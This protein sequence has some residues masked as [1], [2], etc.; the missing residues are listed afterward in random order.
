MKTIVT[1]FLSATIYLAGTVPARSQVG[2]VFR[3]DTIRIVANDVLIEVATSDLGK[4]TLVSADIPGKLK[5][6]LNGLNLL[7]INPPKADEQIC[8][9]YT[10]YFGDDEKDYYRLDLQTRKKSG[11]KILI[12]QDE[13]FEYNKGSYMLVMAGRNFLIRIYLNNMDDVVKITEPEFMNTIA[14]AGNEIPVSRK[15]INGW[16]VQ[17]PDGSFN[18]FFIDEQPPLTNDV[19]E[20]GAGIGAGWIKNEFVSDLHFRIGI[21]IGNKAIVSNIYFAEVEAYYNFTWDG[22]FV[23]NGFLSVGYERNFSRNPEKEKWFGLSLGYLIDRNN[24][25]FGKNTFKLSV[26]KKLNNTF[27]VK[28]EI[29]FN[30]FF[31]NIYPGFRF[32][33]AF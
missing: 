26:H 6:L 2:P 18:R 8:V 30:D 9:R 1:L 33:I 4:N 22:E 23:N 15:R 21:G 28:P 27:S 12:S 20:L 10:N 32:K 13:V 16:L 25:F 31:K 24:D 14:R 11:K 3:A 29:Y 7:E 17:K 19:L 5:A